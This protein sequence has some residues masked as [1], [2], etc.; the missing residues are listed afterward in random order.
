M[1][2][3]MHYIKA[4]IAKAHRSLTVQ[5]RLLEDQVWSRAWPTPTAEQ[6]AGTKTQ[7]TLMYGLACSV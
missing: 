7:R 6:L 1:A 5:V 4:N 3:S 2:F